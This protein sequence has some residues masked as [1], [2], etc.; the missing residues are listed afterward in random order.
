M[1]SLCAIVLLVL[2]LMAATFHA[3]QISVPTQ[4]VAPFLG[5]E[6]SANIVLH[7]SRDDA[8]DIWLQIQLAGT[9]TNDL[10]VAF[11]RDANTDGVLDVEEIET[12]ASGT[13]C[14]LSGGECRHRRNG[15]NAR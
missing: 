2:P 11:G 12:A 4:G 10:E 9:P 13:W 1:E 6:V 7:T 5:T 14:A 3:R 8:R 15:G